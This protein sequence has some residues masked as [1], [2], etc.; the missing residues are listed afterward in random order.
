MKP[1]SCIVA[2]NCFDHLV[3]LEWSRVLLPRGSPA[4]D[5]SIL[6]MLAL[7]PR[8]LWSK[9]TFR[10]EMS[11][12]A[13]VCQQL[14]TRSSSSLNASSVADRV[15]QSLSASTSTDVSASLK[16]HR[17]SEA[18]V[19]FRNL[20]KEAQEPQ[21]LERCLQDFARFKQHKHM[22]KALNEY[23]SH[24]YSPSVAL[25]T[26][27]LQIASLAETGATDIRPYFSNGLGDAITDEQS[28]QA[29]LGYCAR[30]GLIELGEDLF[31][32]YS[33]SLIGTSDGEYPVPATS[34]WTV[35]IDG[36]GRMADF[37][38]AL[39]WFLKWRNSFYSSPETHEQIHTSIAS[40][41]ILFG[42]SVKLLYHQAQRPTLPW[43][44]TPTNL[45]LLPRLAHTLS[46]L[47][48]A[49]ALRPDPLPYLTLLKH[50]R[51]LK[52]GL[53]HKT[54]SDILQLMAADCVPLTTDVINGIIENEYT[55]GKPGSMDS[56]LALYEK[57]RH[58][59]TSD[60]QPDH[61]TFYHVFRS[62]KEPR[63]GPARSHN[64]Y[65]PTRLARMAELPI[66]SSDLTDNP[67]AV[68]RDM[69]SI[70]ARYRM[71]KKDTLFS[72]QA[73]LME[74]AIGAFIRTRDFV[75]C[76]AA[77]DA[78][79]HLRIEP[80]ARMHSKITLGLLRA[81]DRGEAFA[82]PLAGST[83]SDDEVNRL[84]SHIKRLN[85]LCE[86]EG[87]TVVRV[88]RVAMPEGTTISNIVS[89]T[90]FAHE[91]S[92]VPVLETKCWNDRVIPRT[93]SE[94]RFTRRYELRY[95]QPL[96]DLLRRASGSSQRDWQAAIENV[97]ILFRTESSVTRL[98][99]SPTSKDVKA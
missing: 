83:L 81:R 68:F 76:A 73:D 67:R 63:Q 96:R 71:L 3:T 27:V 35:M 41:T 8:V 13:T 84:K 50:T 30:Y 55:L 47:D 94:I 32:R 44:G 51:L 93:E 4:N 1:L 6:T 62:Y 46:E 90:P 9:H 29:L 16:R 86:Y 87:P 22:L 85:S 15:R 20:L 11:W 82:A 34:L 60:F 39:D 59:Q 88:Q 45:R 48:T 99:S 21:V 19:R 98:T 64:P 52:P 5:A 97:G 75:G 40:K 53:M 18:V 95:L 17:A 43:P 78:L 10:H 14:L 49:Y 80:T 12:R 38:G 79:Q 69:L 31:K 42:R 70:E 26:R 91:R 72:I 37:E 25:W 23:I 92:S 66:P 24:G 33:A 77:L 54:S 89:D 2:S 61:A 74:E 65:K 36:R 7:T 58:S 56:I 28:L 57:L